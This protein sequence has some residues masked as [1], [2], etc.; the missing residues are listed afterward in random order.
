VGDRIQAA[1]GSINRN[2]NYINK[3]QVNILLSG[4]LCLTIST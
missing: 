4:S 1:V 3:H 2:Q